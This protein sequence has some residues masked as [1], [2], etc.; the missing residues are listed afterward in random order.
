MEN[1]YDAEVLKN[2]GQFSNS[3]YQHHIFKFS[4]ENA[5]RTEQTTFD[6]AVF[7]SFYILAKL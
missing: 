7:R 5:Y 6:K 4:I 1:T 3:Y 2:R